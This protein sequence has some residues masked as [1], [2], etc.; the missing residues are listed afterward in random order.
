VPLEEGT[1]LEI[2][3]RGFTP[4]RY[5]LRLLS[6][7]LAPHSSWRAAGVSRGPA[8]SASRSSPR[9]PKS[10]PTKPEAG[11]AVAVIVDRDGTPLA[12][13]SEASAPAA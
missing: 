13:P 1:Y 12:L 3:E 5:P 8:A 9:P 2:T 7:V 4:P 10:K 11:A 6:G